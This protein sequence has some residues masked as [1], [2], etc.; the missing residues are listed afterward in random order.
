MTL[1]WKRLKR[2]LA[3]GQSEGGWVAVDVVCW[4]VAWNGCNGG[5]A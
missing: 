2:N 3:G 5:W 4:R 1:K